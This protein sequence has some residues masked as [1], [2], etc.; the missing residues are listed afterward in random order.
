AHKDAGVNSG[1]S[2]PARNHGRPG[3]C[4][5]PRSVPT[6]QPR[7]NA[8]ENTAL[9]NRKVRQKAPRNGPDARPR[10]SAG[11]KEENTSQSEGNN[12]A[13][14]SRAHKCNRQSRNR[15]RPLAQRV[16]FIP[17]DSWKAMGQT[18]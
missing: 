16:S 18:F 3:N 12:A 7:T 17:D 8:R 13:I 11:C 6:G 5:R 1:T 15:L 10:S 2:Q 9:N 4:T 14:T